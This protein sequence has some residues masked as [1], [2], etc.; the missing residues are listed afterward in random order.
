MQYIIRILWKS[1]HLGAD[2]L[3]NASCSNTP[4][5]IST[6]SGYLIANV[7]LYYLF[8]NNEVNLN[9]II[10]LFA[11]VTM[12]IYFFLVYLVQQQ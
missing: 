12:I 8:F 4:I 10:I 1:V 9:N 2:A 3:N 7:R 5:L 6:D 11:A